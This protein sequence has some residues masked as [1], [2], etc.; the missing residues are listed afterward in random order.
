MRKRSLLSERKRSLLSEQPT[1]VC[2]Y[3]YIYIYI[4]KTNCIFE[5]FVQGWWI[6]PVHCSPRT[7]RLQWRVLHCFH[8]RPFLALQFL[9]EEMR[10]HTTMQRFTHP[11]MRGCPGWVQA[12]PHCQITEM[13]RKVLH[14]FTV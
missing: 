6:R 8:L 13:H 14:S 11:A 10:Q 5:F 1:C 9:V 7:Y 12:V 2:V 4:S 3:I